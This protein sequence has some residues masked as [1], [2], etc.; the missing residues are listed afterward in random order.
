MGARIGHAGDAGGPSQLMDHTTATL[1]R[2]QL[3]SNPAKQP[4]CTAR[5]LEASAG[6]KYPGRKNWLDQSAIEIKASYGIATTGVPTS[7][8]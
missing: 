4:H 1:R 2:T 6:A 7:T 3:A 8:R 5:A